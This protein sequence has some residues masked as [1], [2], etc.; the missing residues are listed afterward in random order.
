MADTYVD[1]TTDDVYS[2]PSSDEARGF[3]RAYEDRSKKH[4]AN[5]ED[6]MKQRSDAIARV[7]ADLDNITSEMRA[8]Q[9]G[10]G[11]GQINLPL[12]AL[13]AGLLSPEPGG[14]IGNFGSELSRGLTAMGST[15]AN[16]RSQDADF[17]NRLAQLRMKS[18]E[19]EDMPL[20]D[21]AVLERQSQLAND[22]ARARVEAALIRAQFAAGKN[23]ADPALIKEWKV[24]QQEPGNEGKPLSEYQK[25]KSRLGADRNTPASMREWDAFNEDREKKGQPRVSLDEWIQMKAS[26]QGAGKKAGEARGEADVALPATIQDLDYIDNTLERIE[27]HPGAKNAFGMMSLVPNRPGSKTSDFENL[28]KQLESQ[29]FLTA[30]QKMRGLGALTEMEGKK[31]TDA[32]AALSTTQSEE[33][34]KENLGVLRGYLSKSR[35]VAMQKA[36]KE[37]RAVDDQ[38]PMKGAVKLPDGSWGIEKDGQWFRLE[39]KK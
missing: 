5:Y 33:Q 36:G 2:V 37:P 28:R 3:L 9:S 21:R 22:N 29:T 38:P 30:V 19:L 10:A 24:W 7:R 1:E 4:A 27:K 39:K 20:K 25:F 35:S 6:I 18:A 31:V 16:Q 15:I 8:K 13:G 26:S 23:G 14:R 12:L 34:F 32:V 17:Q 11:P